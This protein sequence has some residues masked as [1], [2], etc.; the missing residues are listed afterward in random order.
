VNGNA[1]MPNVVI[2]VT[3][4]ATG[5]RVTRLVRK[6]YLVDIRVTVSVVKT[7]RQN[8]CLVL[9]KKFQITNLH[10]GNNIEQNHGNK[11]MKTIILFKMKVHLFRMQPLD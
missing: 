3:N 7:V 1:R 8:A 10:P 9:V 5:N 2:L 11:F 4:F 6:D